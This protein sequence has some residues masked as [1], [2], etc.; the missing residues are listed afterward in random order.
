MTIK[1]KKTLMHFL[2]IGIS[3]FLFLIGCEGEVSYSMKMEVRFINATDSLIEFNFRTDFLSTQDEKIILNPN[4][5]S[6]IFSGYID[7]GKNPEPETC[8][9]EILITSF[10]NGQVNRIMINGNRC[11]VHNQ[12]KST[13]F[14]N[15]SIETISDRTFRYTYTFTEEDLKD[16]MPCE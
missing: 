14:S 2:P 11:I 9:N 16:G 5:N 8:C 10:R 13:D 1:Q 15:Y 12:E 3:I 4:S 6:P 7:S